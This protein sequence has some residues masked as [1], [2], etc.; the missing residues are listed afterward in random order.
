MQVVHWSPKRDSSVNRTV[1][2]SI[3]RTAGG[4]C[5]GGAVGGGRGGGARGTILIGLEPESDDVRGRVASADS[6]MLSSTTLC[7]EII[8]NVVPII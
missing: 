6:V 5:V 8:N 2:K 1:M 3:E 4:G 7:H